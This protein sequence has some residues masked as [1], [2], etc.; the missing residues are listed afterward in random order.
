MTRPLTA[1]LLAIALAYAASTAALAG[2]ADTFEGALPAQVEGTLAIEVP[3]EADEDG[4]VF[5]YGTLTTEAGASYAVEIPE[6]VLTAAGLPADGGAT[7]A[8][9]GEETEEFGFPMYRVTALEKR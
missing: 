2:G 8:T 7:R 3:P 4:A 9:L 5:A 1:L 6:A